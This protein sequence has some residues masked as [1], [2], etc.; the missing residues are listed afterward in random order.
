MK[1]KIITIFWGIM[2]MVLSGLLLAEML[3]FI[4]FGSLSQQGRAIIFWV[5]SAA[6]FLTYLLS[7]IKKWGW[8][9]PAL[10][11]A[12]IGWTC[13]RSGRAMG[14]VNLDWP[15]LAALSIPFYVG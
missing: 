2:L 13:L 5:A 14:L 7:G 6:F 15:I 12:V 10:I 1:S 11:C 8:L 9:F 3:G 4:N